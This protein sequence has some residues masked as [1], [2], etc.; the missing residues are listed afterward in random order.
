MTDGQ[1][2][3]GAKSDQ[4]EI[5]HAIAT[6]HSGIALFVPPGNRN[7]RFTE[8]GKLPGV[9]QIRDNCIS[10]R[11]KLGTEFDVP[12]DR[13]TDVQ[14]PGR[15][16][17][18]SMQ[19]GHDLKLRIGGTQYWFSDLM[20]L[21]P[22]APSDTIVM[23]LQPQ[24]R[25]DRTESARVLVEGALFAAHVNG[26]LGALPEIGIEWVAQKVI[27]DI[28]GTHGPADSSMRPRRNPVTIAP[29]DAF[30]AA[31]TGTP[32]P[33]QLIR[34]DKAAELDQAAPGP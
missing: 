33:P 6:L 7:A 11:T 32:V 4:P 8:G 2:G 12:L 16:S 21:W 26:V 18:R 10:F 15:Q 24:K 28:K 22:D 14:V 27:G 29:A 9:L 31:L 19:R 13:V 25:W 3:P 5:L 1:P 30:R 23:N 20:L 34:P 17:S